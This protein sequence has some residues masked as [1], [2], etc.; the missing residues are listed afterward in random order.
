MPT[1]SM[2]D[3]IDRLRSAPEGSRAFDREIASLVLGYRNPLPYLDVW[4]GNKPDGSHV[5]GPSSEIIHLYTTSV[6]AALALVA[7]RLPGW[8]VR[9]ETGDPGRR[10]ERMRKARAVVEPDLHN[11]AGWKVGWRDAYADTPALALVI[12]LLTAISEDRHE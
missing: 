2:Q 1:R 9:L 6:D 11:D 8:H 5:R 4:E 10:D 3:I 12:A 7:A